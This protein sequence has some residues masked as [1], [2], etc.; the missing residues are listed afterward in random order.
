[1]RFEHHDIFRRLLLRVGR[2]LALGAGVGLF[3]GIVAAVVTSGGTDN[4][5]RS[6]V[7]LRAG[8]VAFA[9]AFL[10][11]ILL[12]SHD[13]DDD[14]DPDPWAPVPGGTSRDQLT[15]RLRREESVNGPSPDDPMIEPPRFGQRIDPQP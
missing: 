10:F 14:A 7:G 5:L 6:D 2:G 13:D 4:V 11:T 15:Q 3:V 8:L 12:P 9:V 1:M